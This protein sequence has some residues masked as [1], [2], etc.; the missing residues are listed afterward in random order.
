[1]PYEDRHR[2]AIAYMS[3]Q[4]NADMGSAPQHPAFSTFGKLSLHVLE[5]VKTLLK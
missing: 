4:S 3:C 2:G 1:M 5:L